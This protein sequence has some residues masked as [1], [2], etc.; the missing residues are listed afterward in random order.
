MFSYQYMHITPD[1]YTNTWV[2]HTGLEEWV[3][4]KQFV[5]ARRLT[6]L[7]LTPNGQWRDDPPVIVDT[8][9]DDLDWRR[10]IESGYRS[11]PLLAQDAYVSWNGQRQY[12][13]GGNCNSVSLR[14]LRDFGGDP[15]RVGLYLNSPISKRKPE[16]AVGLIRRVR[17]VQ[18]TRTVG[19]TQHLA[20]SR[21]AARY[22]LCLQ[23][24]HILGMWYKNEFLVD[25]V[26]NNCPYINNL[27]GVRYLATEELLS[28]HGNLLAGRAG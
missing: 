11:T 21:I 4:A 10:N 20:I 8:E 2:Y 14:N 22:Y 17:G 3:Y 16:A 12:K 9:H 25:E 5:M 7:R 26:H 27:E 13:F 24:R 28:L 23:G 6:C 15:A 18:K 1:R 19:I